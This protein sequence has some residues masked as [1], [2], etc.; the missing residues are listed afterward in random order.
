MTTQK[1]Y[2][3]YCKK[4][5][6]AAMGLSHVLVDYELNITQGI[7]L[8]SHYLCIAA[9]TDKR[10]KEKFLKDMGKMYDY[11]KTNPFFS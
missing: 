2:E 4:A 5:G 6:N 8:I 1:D 9:I 11:A 7:F 3:E 10:S